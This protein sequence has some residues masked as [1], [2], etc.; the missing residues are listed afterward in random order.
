LDCK[1]DSQGAEK[2][3][4]FFRSLAMRVSKLLGLLL[5]VGGFFTF[6]RGTGWHV[7]YMAL[8]AFLGFLALLLLSPRKVRAFPMKTISR[9]GP[10]VARPGRDR[11]LTMGIER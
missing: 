2:P 3:D 9:R 6:T 11:R 10:I 4:W 8:G 5:L 7:G 1:A